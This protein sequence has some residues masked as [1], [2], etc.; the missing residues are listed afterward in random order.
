MLMLVVST[1]GACYEAILGRDMDYISQTYKLKS[2]E[3]SPPEV[4][5]LPWRCLML[6]PCHLTSGASL[7]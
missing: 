5:V 1:R 3:L 4:C 2:A 6:V 7:C